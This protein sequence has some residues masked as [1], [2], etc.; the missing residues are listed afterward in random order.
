MAMH[1]VYITAQSSV[2]WFDDENEFTKNF[3]QRAIRNL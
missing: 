3:D 1:S 2:Y